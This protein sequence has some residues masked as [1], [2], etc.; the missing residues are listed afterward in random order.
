[1]AQETSYKR[2]FSG[3]VGSGMKSVF[4]DKGR[5]Y[6]IL[7]HKVSSKYHKAGDNQKIIVDEIEIGRDPRCQVRFDE[8][9]STVSRRH[10]AIVRDGENWKLVQL[11]KTNST[12]LNGHKVENE[13]Y[14]QNGDEIQLSTNGPKL[15][16]ITPSGDKGLV[17]SIGM[18][19]R[20]SLFRQQAL[21]PYKTAITILA[22]L[23]I[24]GC[25]FGAFYLRELYK[26][27]QEQAVLIA[28]NEKK[29]AQALAVQDS[30]LTEAKT[31]ADNLQGE[32]GNLKK[33]FSTVRKQQRQIAVNTGTIDN[34]AINANLPSVFFIY[35]THMDVTLPS[36][37]T[38][39]IDCSQQGAPGWCGTGF[40]LDDGRFVTARHVVEPWFFWDSGGKT[41]EDMAELNYIVNNGGKVVTHFIAISS[42]GQKFNLTN[43]QFRTSKSHDRSTTL[44]NGSRLSLAPLDASDYAVAHVGKSGV[45]HADASLSKNL[46]RGAKLTILGFPMGLGA[47]S[48]TSINPIMSNSTVAADGLQNGI[49]L[50]TATGFEQGNSGGPVFFTN[51]E[52][53]MVVVGI[54][55]ANAGRST[56]FIVPISSIN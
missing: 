9:F 35:S 45:L 16:F 55:S 54:V 51:T 29:H 25:G 1:M 50:T 3:S 7:E 41:D 56:G 33:Q 49:I 31:R 23:L 13:W 26:R 24:L 43:T 39:T 8:Q 28:E 11:S 4:G 15:G 2:S 10:A 52:G 47:N 18:T 34:N 32:L 37:E 6:Y 48:P 44:E 14:L 36:G 22:C 19:A 5:R 21:R 53:K 38:G 46:E 27:N 12:Y 17:K 42:S 30:L 40:L 20:L